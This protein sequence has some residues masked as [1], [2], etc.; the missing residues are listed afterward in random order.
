MNGSATVAFYLTFAIFPALIFLLSLLPYLPM[1]SMN[2]VVMQALFQLLPR[3]SASML[4]DTV[5]GV[6]TKKHQGVLSIGAALT[7]WSAS[8]GIYSLMQQLNITRGVPERRSYLRTRVIALLLVIAFGFFAVLSFA[9][10]MGGDALDRILTGAL[11]W[12]TGMISLA[13]QAAR[14]LFTAIALSTAFSLVNHFGPDVKQEFRLLSPGSALASALFLASSLLFKAYV[15]NFGNYNAMYGG[16]GAVIVLMLWLNL[17]GFV[18]LLGSEVNTLLLNG[19]REA[20]EGPEN[21]AA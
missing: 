18:T 10:L 13:Y 5:E 19:A 3:D 6:V 15:T 16:I 4:Q 21:M 1:K 9:L 7:L 12:W 8:T 11:P 14:W 17:L 20:R 2:E